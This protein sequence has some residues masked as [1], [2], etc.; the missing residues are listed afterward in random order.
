MTARKRADHAGNKKMKKRKVRTPPQTAEELEERVEASWEGRQII[1]RGLYVPLEAQE[2]RTRPPQLLPTAQVAAL[3]DRPIAVQPL[4]EMRQRMAAEAAER[5]ERDAAWRAAE[6][7]EKEMRARVEREGMRGPGGSYQQVGEPVGEYEVQRRT[8]TRA[9]MRARHAR[10][11]FREDEQEERE[12][13]EKRRQR[14]QEDAAWEIEVA[15]RR[16]Q[17]QREWEQRRDVGWRE[18]RQ[19]RG[20]PTE[21][22]AEDRRQKF[23]RR[24]AEYERTGKQAP[25]SEYLSE[26][27]RDRYSRLYYGHHTREG[28]IGMGAEDEEW[29]AARRSDISSGWRREQSTNKD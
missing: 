14:E 22:W 15:R 6:Q 16:E 3:I 5:E 2:T 28:L 19:K 7:Q 21:G 20:K 11:E 1:Q 25:G 29:Y 13:Y 10:G 26:D 12:E 8:E 18:K 24:L 9:E 27:E 23:A 17:S 4:P